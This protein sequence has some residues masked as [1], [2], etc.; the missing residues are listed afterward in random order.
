MPEVTTAMLLH[1]AVIGTGA[2]L[3]MDAWAMLRKRLLGVPALNYGLVGRWLAWLPRG[4]FYHHPIAATPSVRGEQ[5]IGWIAHYLTGI[6][7]AGILLGLWGLDWVRQ[8]TLAPALIVGLGSVAAPFLLMQPAM[9]AG[10]AASRTPRPNL[11]RMHSL[12][13]HAVFGVGMYVAG[14]AARLI[15]YPGWSLA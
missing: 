3:V 5:A 8:P 14:W 1:A 12:V 7:F 9:G 10:I 13:T 4:R 6:A 11:A 15:A 2:T